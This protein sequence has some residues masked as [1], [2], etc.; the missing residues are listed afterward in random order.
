MP[1]SRPGRPGTSTA[2]GPPSSRMRDRRPAD[3]GTAARRG[4]TRS[5]RP[6][7]RPAGCG[8]RGRRG[9]V[10][11]IRPERR[12]ARISVTRS[13][14]SGAQRDSSSVAPGQ[15]RVDAVAEQD[16]GPVHVADAGDH[17]LVHQQP[18]DRRPA[19]GDAGEG[20]LA[21]GR[22]RSGSGPSRARMAST[23]DGLSTSHAVG[24][25]RSRP[26]GRRRSSACGPRR[27]RRRL[28]RRR[29]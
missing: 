2:C 23:S 11:T 7:R 1:V 12:P 9:S 18:G 28:A 3:R 22:R 27:R 24:P 13:D 29:P 21:V 16:L 10:V 8:G 5:G 19:A 25:R 26:P 14:H 15:V 6:R 17:R 20:R 4:G